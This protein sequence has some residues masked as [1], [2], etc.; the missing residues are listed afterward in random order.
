MQCSLDS[1]LPSL[2]TRR[3]A[4]QA[5]LHSCKVHLVRSEHVSAR[6]T[7][8]SLRTC[9][10]KPT[11]FQRRL[12]LRSMLT[13]SSRNTVESLQSALCFVNE[14]HKWV[15]KRERTSLSVLHVVKDTQTSPS[16]DIATMMLSFSRNV[17]ST[18]GLISPLRR[19]RLR[20]KSAYG[21]QDSSILITRET[22]E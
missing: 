1:N 3:K 22:L 19:Q 13:P 4:R 16:D 5:Q 21:I 2:K 20:L 18:S 10:R 12:S 17:L 9:D 8:D 15:M 11:D 6:N 14:L 7:L